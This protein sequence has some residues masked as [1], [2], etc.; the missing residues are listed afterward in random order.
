MANATLRT[1][2]LQTLDNS[3]LIPIADIVDVAALTPLQEGVD[4]YLST[5]NAFPETYGAVGDGA[6]DDTVAVQA[7]INSGRVVD[8]LGKIYSVSSL[9]IPSN[10]RMQHIHF[11]AVPGAVNSIPTIKIDGTS[12]AKANIILWDVH[13]NGNR[14]NKTNIAGPE[15]GDGE[16]S[17]FSVLGTVDNLI[18][19]DCSASY[20]GTDGLSLFGAVSG[21]S[22]SLTNISVENFEALWNRRHGVS[23]DTSK[24]VRFVGGH[25][26][27]NGRDLD[28]SSPLSH[29][30][31]GARF[32]G[33]LY[34]N[35]ADIE[36]YGAT[37]VYSTHVENTSFYE[38]ECIQN[39]G[40]GLQFLPS[41]DGKAEATW[42]PFINT[43]IYG[44][45]FDQGI[46]AASS[47]RNSIQCSAVGAF[48]VGEFSMDGFNV[49]GSKLENSISLNFVRGANVQAYVAF[50]N[51]SAFVFH[52]FVQNCFN[53]HLDLTTPQTLLIYQDQSTLTTA[54]QP[55]VP[56]VPTILSGAVT[57]QVNSQTATLVSASADHGTLYRI[58]GEVQLIG[59]SSTVA[60]AFIFGGPRT[61]LDA[62][63]SMSSSFDGTIIPVHYNHTGNTLNIKPGTFAT[64]AVTA[65]VLVK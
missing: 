21:T 49:Y 30:M 14:Q 16:L 29:G 12:V 23:L 59:G 8:G 37:P 15:G 26:N 47:E 17:G 36:S 32:G 55:S 35:G 53:A 27:F 5:R 25:W 62:Q 64:L 9:S 54:I 6:T 60:T 38:I 42:R 45:H 46:A 57:A 39:F 41:A 22:L 58:E 10:C 18:I 63:A 65:H 61:V 2:F 44:G 13:V 20:C 51:A 40:M 19:R 43:N 34:G 4:A 11:F 33:N 24:N 56:G 31:R 3:V 7:A 50:P 1:D 52:A 48:S 28:G